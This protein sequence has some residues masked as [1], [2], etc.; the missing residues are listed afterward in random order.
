[1]GRRGAS[2]ASGRV[3]RLLFVRLARLLLRRRLRDGPCEPGP[4]GVVGLVLAQD[5][6]RRFQGIK[7]R[8]LENKFTGHH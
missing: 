7:R 8:Q 5:V 6:Q 2:A 3:V 1:M 4:R